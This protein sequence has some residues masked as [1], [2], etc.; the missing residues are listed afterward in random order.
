MKLLKEKKAEIIDL[1]KRIKILTCL[2]SDHRVWTVSNANTA[3]L[4]FIYIF[5]RT[6]LFF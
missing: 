6:I 2:L 3:M 4:F 1:G 5:L